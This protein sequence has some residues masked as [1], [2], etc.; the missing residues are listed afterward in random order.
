MFVPVFFDSKCSSFSP[1]SVTAD[2][3]PSIFRTW[4]SYFKGDMFF[5]VPWYVRLQRLVD[6][7]QP[8]PRKPKW[9]WKIHHLKMYFL[10]KMGIFQCHVSFQGCNFHF[11]SWIFWVFETTLSHFFGDSS[12]FKRSLIEPQLLVFLSPIRWDVSTLQTHL[13]EIAEDEGITGCSTGGGGGPSRS[14]W[15]IVQGELEF[16]SRFVGKWSD[17]TKRIFFKWVGEKPPPRRWFPPGT[18]W[19]VLSLQLKNVYMPMKLHF[20]LLYTGKTKKHPTVRDF[21]WLCEEKA[22]AKEMPVL[23]CFV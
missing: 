21:G 10:L 6:K 14:Q 17:L 3:T 9:Q 15:R 13:L 4:R 16:S 5:L 1:G 12:V 7:E 22:A 19:F 20:W 18:R 23:P 11:V 2:K 8:T